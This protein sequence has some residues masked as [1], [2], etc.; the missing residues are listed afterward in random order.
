MFTIKLN[1]RLIGAKDDFGKAPVSSVN[2]Q[3]LDK[4]AL[5]AWRNFVLSNFRRWWRTFGVVYVGHRL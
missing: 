3:F 1:V 2:T 5:I 4:R